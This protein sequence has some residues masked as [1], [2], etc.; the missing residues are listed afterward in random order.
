M[1]LQEFI[2]DLLFEYIEKIEGYK[3]SKGEIAPWVI[4]SHETRKILSSHKTKQAAKNHLQQMHIHGN[5]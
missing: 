2:D 5:K 3:N 1:N 4:K